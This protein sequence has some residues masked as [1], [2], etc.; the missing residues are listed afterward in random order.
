[1]SKKNHKDSSKREFFRR[2]K[3]EILLFSVVVLIYSNTIWNDYNLDDEFVTGKN[4]LTQSG[5]KGIKKI[6]T[7]HY[8]EGSDT[9]YKYEYRPVVKASFA[10]EY[11]VFG[12]RPGISHL[13]NLLIYATTVV[14][15]YKLLL[16][17][18]KEQN[19]LFSFLTCLLYAVHP[20]HTEVVA[21]LKNRDE[22][23]ALLFA[24]LMCRSLFIFLLQKN[25]IHVLYS[26][27][28]LCLAVFSKRDGIIFLVLFPLMALYFYRKEMNWLFIPFL[29]VIPFFTQKLIKKNLVNHANYDRIFFAQEN[30]L[31]TD[32]SFSS[33][34]GLGAASFGF[35]LKM[36]LFP[37]PLCFF[38]GYNQIQ[39][40]DFI[41]IN[42][43][44]PLLI[45]I[46]M[47]F[48][49][50]KTFT[51]DKKLSFGIAFFL[52]SV[53]GYLNLILPAVGIVAERFAFIP[54]I[55][56]CII[57]VSALGYIFKID[58]QNE[59]NWQFS[60]LTTGFK[61][62]FVGAAIIFSVLTFSRN[63]TW[64][65]RM[66][67]FTT[68]IIHI[69]QSAKAHEVLGT[70]Y[71]S[72]ASKAGNNIEMRA[73]ADSAIL[74]Y[75]KATEIFPDYF[76]VYN[77]MGSIYFNLLSDP[78]TPIP[79]FEKAI[80][81]DSNYV[82]AL[83]NLATCYVSVKDTARAIKTIEK[84]V[85][86]DQKKNPN[87]L[88]MAATIYNNIRNYDKSDNFISE[89]KKKFPES[90]MPHIQHANI[91]MNRQDTSSAVQQLSY[92]VDKNTKNEQVYRFLIGYYARR[93][94]LQEAEHFNQLLYKLNENNR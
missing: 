91:L 54:S 38:Y 86:K 67:L 9:K 24:L 79:Y 2:N 43:L 28:F 78:V 52:I 77:S 10:I 47:V 1:M 29:I 34:L 16:F 60:R 26:V 72:L 30:P 25:Y 23:L 92:A 40:P 48:I 17:L 55:G 87:A 27:L 93:G 7:S 8:T 12:L 53:A 64:K 71:H 41:S 35:Y 36:F 3:F 68:D 81:L 15:L 13:I 65:S 46:L 56:L 22:I 33:K 39:I 76:I 44:L 66:K 63:I 74:H 90:E 51:R 6:F 11:S 62:T 5:I 50:I 94:K 58:F 83:L 42:F 14:L 31:F 57:F 4:T 19:Q 70:E 88:L 89:A 21:S 80:Q 59:I 37:F 18:F 82:P 73:Y 84:A 61:Y 85:K 32:H 69:P 45:G 75:K 20:L 49:C